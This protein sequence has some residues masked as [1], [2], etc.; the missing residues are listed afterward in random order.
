MNEVSHWTFGPLIPLAPFHRPGHICLCM[1]V[2]QHIHQYTWLFYSAAMKQ[3]VSLT[4]VL[5]MWYYSNGGYTLASSVVSSLDTVVGYPHLC[6]TIILEFNISE[7]SRSAQQVVTICVT[8]N[9]IYVI[10][11]YQSPTSL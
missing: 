6:E 8:F 2:D 10:S 9:K 4:S 11:V 7:M 5:V 3:S 1:L